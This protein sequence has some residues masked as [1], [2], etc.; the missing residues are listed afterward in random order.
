VGTRNSAG[1]SRSPTAVRATTSTY[2]ASSTPEMKHLRPE[3]TQSSPS[4][5]ATVPSRW[6]FE[7]ASGSVIAKTTFSEPSA[8]PGRKSA[9]CASVPCRAS[10]VPTIAGETT[11]SSS[12]QPAAASS[13]HTIASSVIPPPPPPYDDGTL[14]PI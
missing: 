9:R 14:T 1:W 11:R 4:R 6:K 8:M 12:G 13:S 10:T 3:S 5:V 2:G 7:P